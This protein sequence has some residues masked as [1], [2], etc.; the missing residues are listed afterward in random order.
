MNNTHRNSVRYRACRT[1]AL[2]GL[3][4]LSLGLS[5]RVP[6][7][8]NLIDALKAGQFDVD[9]RYRFEHVDDDSPKVLKDAEASTLRTALGYRTGL[10][11]GFGAYLQMEDVRVLGPER[12]NDGG[13]NALSQYATVVDPPG[14]E[15]NQGYLSYAGWRSWRLRVGREEWVL[16]DQRFIG[17]VGWRQNHQSYDLVRGSYRGLADTV[18][19]YAYVW[20]VNRIFGQDNPNPLLRHFAMHSQLLHASWT[21]SGWGRLSA[22]GYLLDFA[23]APALSTQTWGL[24]FSGE[25]ALRGGWSAQYGAEYAKQLDY[26][27]N[28]HAIDAD[29]ALGE[30][31]LEYRLGA[32]LQSVGAK[33]SYEWLSG[34][35][36][37]SVLQT[38]LAT[39]HAFQGWA[40][41]F[42]TTPAD[43]IRDAYATLSAQV[44]GAKLM[45]VYH[46]F[47][48]DHGGYRYGHEVDVLLLRR[49]RTHYTVGF[50]YAGYTAD[51]NALNVARNP[52]QNTDIT[53]YWAFAQ[54]KF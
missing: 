54:V 26:A 16:D 13:A 5:P 32:W 14:T 31:G 30:L 8:D 36:G 35:G 17:D 9:L 22:Y 3:G 51:R 20:N 23:A 53:K 7:A 41:K 29:Y 2:I 24:R 45:A 39:G 1:C 4:I 34:D 33:L 28:P 19:D 43:G 52:G 25:H 48:A 15:L 18:L 44:L 42:L 46:D 47:R 10:F 12:Y 6:A 27:A 49:F 50:K 21:G 37:T 38:P 40:D 11:R